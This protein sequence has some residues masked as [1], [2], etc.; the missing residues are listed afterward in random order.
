MSCARAV[1][2]LRLI[3]PCSVSTNKPLPAHN[4]LQQN[5]PFSQTPKQGQFHVPKLV[6]PLGASSVISTASKHLH[7]DL[8]KA[9]EALE[10]KNLQAANKCLKSLHVRVEALA[11]VLEQTVT[12]QQFQFLHEMAQSNCRQP[13]NSDHN[14]ERTEVATHATS[15]N[16]N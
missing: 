5:Q 8:A 7:N 11:N 16:S 10:Q 3:K 9:I 6:A 2:F 12:A 13:I 4:S 14:S 1:F 15:C